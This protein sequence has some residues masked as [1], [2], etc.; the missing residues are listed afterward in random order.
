M[1]LLAMLPKVP[2]SIT[3]LFRPIY[4]A[5]ALFSISSS[6]MYGLGSTKL[7]VVNLLYYTVIL[8]L[9]PMTSNAIVTYI[10]M[11]LFIVFFILAANRKWTRRE[12]TILIFA[13][14]IACDLQAAI[15]L[16]SNP[17]LLGDS[18]NQ[19]VSFLGTIVNRNPIAFSITPGALCGM[20]LLL[21]DKR[22]KSAVR[23]GFYIV[24]CLTCSFAVFAR[25]YKCRRQ[26]GL[27]FP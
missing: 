15:I 2:G 13:V 11:A 27:S 19:H 23:K 12:I 10:S 6:G 3:K 18:G 5:V 17:S 24:S 22:H 4:I 21:Y 25:G 9:H 14:L 16:Y 7:H 20:L 26:S 8:L 1:V